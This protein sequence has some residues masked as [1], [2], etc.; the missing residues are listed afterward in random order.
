MKY[1]VG[2]IVLIALIPAQLLAQDRVVTVYTYDRMPF[3]GQLNTDAEGF[4]NQITRLVFENAK[5][6]YVFEK[7]PVTRIFANLT[8]PGLSCIAGTF[9]N[10]EREQTYTF[11]SDFIYQDSPPRYLIR[12]TDQAHY[13]AIK[14]IK[15]LLTSG[16]TLGVADKYSYGTWVD[17]NILR[18]KPATAVVN[19]RDDQSAFMQM[20]VLKRFD[21]IFA[22]GEEAAYNLRNNPDFRDTISVKTLPDAPAGNIRWIMCNKDFPPDLLARL[23][24]SIPEIKKTRAY[25][26]ITTRL[27]K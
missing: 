22:S 2:L 19:I 15:A 14:D 27:P 13:A 3:F 17:E 1:S 12:T 16:K 6:P 10:P 4:I 5:I 11:S 26:D 25:R 24:K 7:V 18:Y 21:Y 23:N 20:L 9:R 8:Q